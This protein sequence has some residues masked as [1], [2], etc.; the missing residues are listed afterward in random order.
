[1]KMR[2]LY[3]KDQQFA[4]LFS[5]KGQSEICG[6][7][8]MSN[9]LLYL[10]HEHGPKFPRLFIH[11]GLAEK[12]D[13]GQVVHKM[14]KLCHTSKEKGTNSVQLKGCSADVIRHARYGFYDL[15]VHGIYSDNPT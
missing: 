2:D 11:E 13:D 14:F 9:V 10:R 3:Q 7:T 8:A 12:A 5:S 15:Y 6:P 4:D 1:H